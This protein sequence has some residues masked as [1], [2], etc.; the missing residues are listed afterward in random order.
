MTLSINFVY[1]LIFV[2]KSGIDAQIAECEFNENSAGLYGCNLSTIKSNYNANLSRVD[3]QHETGH[4]DD[5]VKWI[6]NYKD[7]KVKT[8]SSIFCQKFPNLEVLAFNGAELESIDVDSLE[9][10]ENLGTLSLFGNK[11]RE[12]LEKVFVNQ[13]ELKKLTLDYN[14]IHF[15][16]SEIFHPLVK[17]DWLFL[18]HNKLQSIIPEWFVNLQSLKWFSVN[19]NKISTIPPNCFASLTNLEHL[20][21]QENRIE[22]LNSNSFSNLEFLKELNLAGN[23]ISDLPVNIFT[24]LLSLE[25]LKLSNNRLTAIHSHSFDFHKRLKKF[26]LQDNAIDKIDEKIVNNI[27]ISTLDMRNNICSQ[28]NF[29]DASK[30]EIRSGLGKCFDNYKPRP[31]HLTNFNKIEESVTP[32]LSF[33]C[34]KALTGHG[35]IIGEAVIHR[36]DF[37]W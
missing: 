10:C 4:D 25:V 34:G 13:K 22:D 3:G 26:Y 6:E 21:L 15:L 9:N 28:S 32:N 37:P 35:T 31:R 11:I 27:P 5:D 1:F 7:H 2:F 30:S 33:S 17:L 14:E 24:P 20:Y 18:N 36:G 16:H 8:I 12:L 23:K 29:E 19:T